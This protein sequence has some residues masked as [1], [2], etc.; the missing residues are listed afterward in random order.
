MEIGQIG[1]GMNVVQPAMSLTHLA[2][3]LEAEP[4]QI[5]RRNMA[6]AIAKAPI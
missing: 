5:L 1:S 2:V 3:K 4:A 6:E